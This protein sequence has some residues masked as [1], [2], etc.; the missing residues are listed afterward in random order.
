MDPLR[1]RRA[2]P[3]LRQSHPVGAGDPRRRAGPTGARGDS[4]PVPAPDH[5]RV[6]GH[7]R[8]P[9]RH[10]LRHRRDRRSRRAQRHPGPATV[11][12]RGPEAEHLRF[13]RGGR[14]R[15]E[16]GDRDGLRP[17]RPP[18]AHAEL[19][20]R[21]GGRRLREHGVP[22]GPRRRG[23]HGARVAPGERGP[24]YPTRDG[25]RRAVGR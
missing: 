17:E 3:R 15:V 8:R 11:R 22:A 18:P 7:R 16:P 14:P 13:P 20:Q 5:R 2:R 19:P 10:R 9:A 25:T 1:A 21:T 6:P 24:L 12:G 23:V 4:P